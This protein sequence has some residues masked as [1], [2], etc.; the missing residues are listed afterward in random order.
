MHRVSS[1]REEVAP[2]QL[3]YV[4]SEV[5]AKEYFVHTPPA[6]VTTHHSVVIEEREERTSSK[7]M[8]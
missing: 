3:L 1:S 8:T 4:W 7:G 5:E 2:E 6:F